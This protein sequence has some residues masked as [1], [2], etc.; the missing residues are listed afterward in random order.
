MTPGE[1]LLAVFDDWRQRVD[2]L[3]VWSGGRG[4]LHDLLRMAIRPRA[5]EARRGVAASGLP[6]ES[7]VDR[8]IHWHYSHPLGRAQYSESDVF[9]A[10]LAALE[11]T[12]I[13]PLEAGIRTGAFRVGRTRETFRVTYRWDVSLEVADI[14]LERQARPGA[15]PGPTK[16]ELRWAAGQSTDTVNAFMPPIEIL[17]AA[18]GRSAVAVDA[19]RAA[20]Q[21]PPLPD[22]F[23]LGDGL[24]VGIMAQVLA[25]LMAMVELGELAHAR[26]RRPGT[27]LF[28][29]PR[30]TLVTWLTKSCEGLSSE[31]AKTAIERLMAGPGRSLRTSL[32]LPNGPLVTVLPLTM[33]PR[34]IDPVV[35]R[36]AA[37]EPAGYGP[38][39]QR[40][41]ERAKLWALWLAQIPR[42][43]VA[44][45]LKLRAPDGRTV[46][47]DLDLL[48]V[49]PD[50][51]KG[52]VLELKWP[53]DALTL[54]ETLKI[55]NN[56]LDASR[57]L[58]KNR[59]VLLDGE[60]TVKMPPGWPAFGDVEWTWGVG[61]PQQLYT[62]PLP[63]SE[64]FTTSFRYVKS[65]GNPGTIEA[66]INAVRNPDVP[67]LGQH[68]TVKKT[69]MHLGRYV[70][71]WDTIDA[72]DLPWRPR[73][74]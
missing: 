37:T 44:E 16:A 41:G 49:D 1:D 21:D 11:S 57:Q 7:L 28:H 60:A 71:R 32:L 23:Q 42:A 34:T 59:R 43:K 2:A 64:M 39:G 45:R 24:T 13:E 29:A 4:R 9:E 56:I 22:D 6:W 40:Q 47:G 31:T 19:W 26:V 72:S 12:R 8:L 67:R 27:T 15:V 20:N 69:T 35:L 52:I 62:G 53:I 51:G 61:T 54:S 46:A 68:Y 66:L 36:T 33:F 74:A 70:I 65:L 48:V 17:Q 18:V 3:A 5:E 30:D 10:L 50:V 63:E 25:G 73:S 14:Y 38:I 58:G 55:D